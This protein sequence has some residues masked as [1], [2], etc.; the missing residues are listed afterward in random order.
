[1]TV[2]AWLHRDWGGGVDDVGWWCTGSDGAFVGHEPA[3]RT[4]E[5]ELVELVGEEAYKKLA[6]RLEEDFGP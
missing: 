6:A 5:A 1:M 4:L 3:Y 2:R